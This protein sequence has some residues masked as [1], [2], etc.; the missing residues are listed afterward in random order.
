[1]RQPSAIQLAPCV[2]VSLLF[3]ENNL[4]NS[5]S[6]RKSVFE[7]VFNAEAQKSPVQFLIKRGQKSVAKFSCSHLSSLTSCE[8]EF[9]DSSI[10]E[11]S[12]STS[13]V[14]KGVGYL[15]FGFP[16]ACQGNCHLRRMNDAYF[17]TADFPQGQSVLLRE[18]Q[19]CLKLSE[20]KLPMHPTTTED[21]TLPGTPGQAV[22]ILQSQ[23]L[24]QRWNALKEK[25]SLSSKELAGERN[26]V[27]MFKALLQK[28]VD[29]SK[30][31]SECMKTGWFTEN[32]L[33]DMS[34]TFTQHI[35]YLS[36]KFGEI[37]SD[38][39]TPDLKLLMKEMTASLSERKPGFWNF[40]N[41]FECTAIDNVSCWI[42]RVTLGS[43]LESF[44]KSSSRI[45]EEMLKN[46]DET[47]KKPQR[48]QQSAKKT[49]ATRESRR[50]D[51]KTTKTTVDKDEID[52]TIGNAKRRL[53]AWS[54]LLK[55]VG[56]R[57]YDRNGDRIRV[58]I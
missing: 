3:P 26:Q 13:P 55:D 8:K 41:K 5:D 51:T 4:Q 32:D 16:S 11:F 28:L 19:K 53:A 58:L 57:I 1:V 35:S 12:L 40:W 14:N 45:L 22:Q 36:A 52:L 31:L 54:R 37:P 10:P 47:A 9:V 17:L 50:K 33:R 25:L 56:R 18:S 24:K 21:V 20:P 43:R 7:I 2:N 49:H 6:V 15:L 46:E 27:L 38:I 48:Q 42:Q 23:L 44:H 34:V 29:A 30:Q 39:L